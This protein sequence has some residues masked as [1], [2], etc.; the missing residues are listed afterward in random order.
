MHKGAAQPSTDLPLRQTVHKVLPAVKAWHVYVCP[1]DLKRRVGI[2]A[3]CCRQPPTDRRFPSQPVIGSKDHPR[4]EHLNK[5]QVPPD[6]L[7][8]VSAHSLTAP[9][10]QRM[11]STHNST[12]LSHPG[13]GFLERQAAGDLLFEK[14]GDHLTFRGPDFLTDQESIWRLS[15]EFQGAGNRVVIRDSHSV[16]APSIHGA[17]ESVKGDEA[18]RGIACMAVKIDA[19]D[20]GV[21]V[22][23]SPS[24]DQPP[25]SQSRG[26]HTQNP[27][28]GSPWLI[29]RIGDSLLV[30]V[31]GKEASPLCTQ[32]FP[33]SP[34]AD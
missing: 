17:Q 18:I 8:D 7:Q 26:R 2:T 16:K 14:E 1:S 28:R 15:M 4:V 20:S 27:G 3:G 10:I 11:R 34:V 31:I 23:V 5:V 30:A 6:G 19:H 32:G 24:V 12:L 21:S 9:A 29:A 33:D 25:E 22:L 13:D